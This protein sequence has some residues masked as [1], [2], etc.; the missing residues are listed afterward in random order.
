MVSLVMVCSMVLTVSAAPA[1]YAFDG[2]WPAEEIKIGVEVYDTTDEQFLAMQEYFN[3]IEEKFNISFMYSESIKSPEDEIE[4][5][6]SSAAAGCQGIFGF[7]NISEIEAVNE[8]AAHGMYYASPSAG[9]FSGNIGEIPYFAGS[10]IVTNAAEDTE[11]N[12]DYLDGYALG[13][14][15][16]QKGYQHIAY[17]EG[18][19]S[20]GVKM[21]VDR[22]E[23][24]LAGLN[25]GGYTSFTDADIVSG[26]PGTDD[27]L[28]AQTTVITSDYDAVVSAFNIAM[29]FQPVIESGKEIGLAT[30]GQANETY[31][32]FFDMGIVKYLI[33]PCEE[34]VYG[35][36]IPMLVNAIMGYEDFIR[37]DNE[38]IQVPVIHWE[39]ETPEQIDSIYD[40]HEAGGWFITE[41]DLARCF[42][43]LNPDITYEEYEN[44]FKITLEEA[45]EIIQ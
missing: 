6:D 2:T 31:K 37:V 26:W 8:A 3:Y 1:D 22:K 7:Y 11:H 44:T 20:F 10:W 4:F 13:Y 21:F 14:A 40:Y 17:C 16:A 28:A 36:F 9:S 19:A 38:P 15:M 25:D 27:F 29:W 45:L 42:K 39:I 18:G 23:G 41:Q 33:Y 43:G 12:G 35:L 5:I 32:D 24:F 30:I 34:V